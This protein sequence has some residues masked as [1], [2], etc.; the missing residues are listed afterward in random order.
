M[1]MEWIGWVATAAFASSY[2]FKE[3]R[4]LRLIQALAAILWI[5]YGAWLGAL[6]VI[7]ANVIVAAAASYSILRPAR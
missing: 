1:K 7:V 2:F 3:P 6:P 4:A 5:G